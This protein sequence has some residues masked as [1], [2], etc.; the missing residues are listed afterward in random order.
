MQCSTF[1]FITFSCP[2]IVVCK[3]L[4][5]TIVVIM[6]TTIQPL[7]IENIVQFSGFGLSQKEMSRTNGVSQGPSKKSYTVFARA[8]VLPR[9]TWESIENND[10]KNIVPFDAAWGRSVFPQLSRI[11]VE[12]IRR[13][14][15]FVIVCM[16]QGHLGTAVYHPRNPDCAFIK[17]C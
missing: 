15:C 9:A 4:Y 2:A 13:T 16:V 17:E 10:I 5:E 7:T 8:A 6:P 3:S 14:G 11:R 12:L 1:M